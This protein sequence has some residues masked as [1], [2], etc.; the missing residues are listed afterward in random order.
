MM[1]FSFKSKM[2]KTVAILMGTLTFSSSCLA[3]P[4]DFAPGTPVVDAI[5]ALGYKASQNIVINGN[6]NGTLSMHMDDTNFDDALQAM[7]LVGN[8]SYDY[9]G[10]T[11]LVA[12]ADELKTIET[13]RL[14][15]LEPELF[16]KQMELIVD[17]GDVVVNKDNHTIAVKGSSGALNRVRNQLKQFDV[18]Q[19]Q[20]NIKCTVIELSKSKKRDI[21]LSYLSDVWSKDTSISGYNG[22]RFSITG[23][24][25]ESLGTGNVLARPNITTF[26]GRKATILMGDKVPVFTS[27]SDSNDT[28][29]DASLTVEYKEVGVKLEVIPRINDRINETITLT[30]K[31]NVSTISQWVESGNNKAPQIS[32]R[33]AETTI[34]VKAGETILLGGL[35][36]EEE[37]KNIKQIPFLSKIPILGE[38]FKSRSIDKKDTEIL[39]AITPTIIHDENGVP[40]VDLQ[41]TTPKLHHKLMEMQ[42]EKIESNVG[43]ETQKSI[44]TMNSDLLK[45]NEEAEKALKT[46]NE[47]LATLKREKKALEDELRAN[48]D[49]IKHIIQSW[50]GDK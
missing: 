8:F 17:S 35:L 13:F 19:Q 44:D 29:S 32:E 46:K 33:S 3:F 38:I 36:K 31:P 47:E 34:R 10:N 48:N 12:P 26:D 1:K 40:R 15:H 25:E 43:T 9:I 23:T 7:S 28:D 41:Q 49:S 5:R 27:T 11:V 20:V 42:Q 30:I 37:I 6:L 21:G 22:F 2:K 39:I 24:H 16:A 45:K 4:I 18:A 14:N 50:E